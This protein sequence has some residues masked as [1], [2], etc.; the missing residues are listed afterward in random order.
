MALIMEYDGT[1]YHGFQLQA[2]LPTIQGETEAALTKLTGERLRVMAASRTDAGVHAKGQVVGFR[3]GSSLPPRAFV[4]G[5]N[6]YLPRD[7]TVKAAYPVE[8]SFDVR[9]DAVSREYSYYILNRSTRSAFGGFSYRVN[10]RLD[11]KA[12]NRACQGLLGEHDF[13][14]FVSCIESGIKSTRRKVY[15]VKVEKNGDMVIFSMVA[16]SFLPHQ[17][18]NTLGALIK[19]GL[20]KITVEQFSDIIEAKQPGLAVP[21]VPACGLFL[22]RVNYPIPL[23]S[24]YGENL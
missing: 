1:R 20:G 7:I 23:E 18:R 21:T 8:D 4:H 17:V 16:N 2:A 19:V 6:Y 11:I 15:Q 10:R 22:M 14:S 9:R 12:M 3:T 5:L 24:R 13:A